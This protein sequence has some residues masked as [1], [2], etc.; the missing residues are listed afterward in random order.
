MVD[1]AGLQNLNLSDQIVDP[2]TGN[3]TTFFMRLLQGKTSITSDVESD[4]E[5]LL[6]L[7]IV[8]D[9]PITGGG[10]LQDAIDLDPLAP[11]IHVG[12]DVSGVAPGSYTNADITVDEFGHVT[13]A[14]NGSG[15]GGGGGLYDISMGVPSGPTTIGDATKFTWTENTGKGLNVQ[16]GSGGLGPN[17]AGWIIPRASGSAW[18][19]AALYLQNNTGAQYYGCSIGLYNSGNSKLINIT[20]F[21]GIYQ[22]TEF[23]QWNSYS[24]R[25]S[26]TTVGTNAAH[27]QGARWL[28]LK[29]DGA[30][31][32]ML[33]ISY[34]GATP[35]WVA[36]T[37][38]ATFIGGYDN[39]F[40]GG[41]FE[42]NV[43][44]PGCSTSVLCYDDDGAAR[45]VGV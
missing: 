20:D 6:A 28:H 13:V 29:D 27:A 30:G 26:T 18:E 42:T 38:V 22:G 24:S 40:I 34:D 12:H 9:A 16:Y 10:V 25:S 2:K 41:F 7:E 17:L 35:V 5:S 4:V 39:V 23:M 44:V 37:T 43:D 32:I 11:Q 15:G 8:A 1:R 19:V 45:V 21:T 14:A 36:S 3:P 31:N 33:G